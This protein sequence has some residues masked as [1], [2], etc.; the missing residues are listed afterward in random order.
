MEL[1][2]HHARGRAQEAQQRLLKW[3][4]EAACPLWSTRGVDR[5]LGGFQ[6]L[7]NGA[8]PVRAPR[9]MRVQPRQVASFM[10]AARL[11]WAGD[12]AGLA[13]HGMSYLYA[14]YRRPDGLFR[15]LI[16]ADGT[17][18]DE[19]A[20]L[21]DQVFVLLAFCEAQQVLGHAVDEA[22]ALRALLYRQF[23]RNGPGFETGTKVGL[24][25]SSNAHMHLFEASL[26]WC[27]ASDDPEWRTLADEIGEL[28]L[29]RFI[30]PASGVLREH[31]DSTWTPLTGVQGR[32]IEPGHHF[33][34]AWLLLRWRGDTHSDVRQVAL[35]L[36]DI[37]ERH[38]IHNGAA[39]NVLLDDFSVHDACARLWPQTERVKAAA[40]AARKTG[41]TRYWTMARDAADSLSLYLQTPVPGSWYDRLMPYGRFI[42][43]P[44]PASTFYHIVGAIAELT[45]AA[46]V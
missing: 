6:E 31:F 12:A 36:I 32:F 18:L 4:L 35:R 20:L 10:G 26:A 23:K 44:A 19:Q 43:E 9:R 1:D 5:T 16:A 37:G 15:T 22:R 40:L 30:D 45:A 28:A 42:E 3:L 38:G 21:Y 2:S 7:L 29:S 11:G 39:V 8:E 46:K 13:A 17:P 24:P 27:E 25:L 41:E 33:E 34:W 14:R